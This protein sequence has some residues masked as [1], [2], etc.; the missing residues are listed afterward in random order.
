MEYSIS[1]L[2]IP[3]VC[4]TYFINTIYFN[5][6]RFF[7]ILGYSLEMPGYLKQDT[8]TEGQKPDEYISGLK[9]HRAGNPMETIVT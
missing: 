5:R 3:Q 6:N 1:S 2:I 8:A 4:G 7:M 9:P